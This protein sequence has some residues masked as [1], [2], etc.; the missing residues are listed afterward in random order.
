M[1]W[2]NVASKVQKKRDREREHD[3]EW[4][5]SYIS[6]TVSGQSHCSN[7]SCRELT[8]FSNWLT[9][10]IKISHPRYANNS[11]DNYVNLRKTIAIMFWVC[12][13]SSVSLVYYFLNHLLQNYEQTVTL[14]HQHMN[15]APF[16]Y[17]VILM[18]YTLE[19]QPAATE[20]QLQQATSGML[21]LLLTINTIIFPSVSTWLQ[22]KRK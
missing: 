3:C 15:R 20:S 5:G 8:A 9:W 13:D 2:E 21:D 11:L 16:H 10:P 12:S 1:V 7:N 17:W 14:W 6:Y 19:I 22:G 4:Y 18:H